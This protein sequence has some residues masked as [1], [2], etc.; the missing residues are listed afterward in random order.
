VQGRAG[1][2]YC[3]LTS[4]RPR[5]SFRRHPQVDHQPRLVERQILVFDAEL[6]ATVLEAPSQPTRN[7]QGTAPMS[8]TSSPSR[9]STEGIEATFARQRRLNG[10]LVEHHV[11]RPAERIGRRDRAKALDQLP[12]NP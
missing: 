4:G 10:G 12:A 9:T 3:T 8:V 2:Q 6:L 5:E 1:S 7:R 11:R